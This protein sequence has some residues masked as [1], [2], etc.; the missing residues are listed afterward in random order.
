MVTWG[1]ILIA[2]GAGESFGVSIWPLI[3]V[4][5]GVSAVLS[6][7]FRGNEE[8]ARWFNCWQCWPGSYRTEPQD[9]NGPRRE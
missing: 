4:V 2:I 3:L 8:T 6:V 1:S 5:I 7:V 9:L